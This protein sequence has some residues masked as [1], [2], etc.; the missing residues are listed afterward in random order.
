[1]SHPEFKFSFTYVVPRPSIGGAHMTET[2]IPP[3]T[4][5]FKHLKHKALLQM[6][7]FAVS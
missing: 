4:Y 7:K 5:L 6:L 3:Q 1:M 2:W